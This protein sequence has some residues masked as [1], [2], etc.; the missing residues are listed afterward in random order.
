M[1]TYAGREIHIF[2]SPR[3]A[4]VRARIAGDGPGVHRRP[5]ADPTRGVAW[6]SLAPPTTE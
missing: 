5:T 2:A 6:I 4:H 1:H 3:I